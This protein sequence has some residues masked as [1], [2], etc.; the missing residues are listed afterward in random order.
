MSRSVTRFRSCAPGLAIAIAIGT[1]LLTSPPAHAQLLAREAA[2]TGLRFPTASATPETPATAAPIESD[3]AEA[4]F[5]GP[6]PP[7]A[8]DDDAS[9]APTPSA[10]A[11]TIGLTGDASIEAGV[12]DDDA[13]FDLTDALALDVMTNPAYPDS[14]KAI[15][16]EQI[17]DDFR[18]YDEVGRR[19]AKR[20]RAPGGLRRTSAGKMQ[21]GVARD[22]DLGFLAPQDLALRAISLLDPYTRDLGEQLCG[23]VGTPCPLPLEWNVSVP[24]VEL[25]WHFTDEAARIAYRDAALGVADTG[26]RV[27]KNG[28]LQNRGERESS[29][30]G[31]SG[32]YYAYYEGEDCGPSLAAPCLRV[33]FARGAWFDT[34]PPWADWSI[35]V[36]AWSVEPLDQLTIEFDRFGN[37]IVITEGWQQQQ[38]A[39]ATVTAPATVKDFF[40]ATIGASVMSARCTTCHALDTRQKIADQHGGLVTPSDV[41]LD[42]SIVTAGALINTC[43]SCHVVG[44]THLHTFDEERWATPTPAQDIDWGSIIASAGA[45]WA[46]EVCQRIVGHLTTPQAR[47]HHFH[48]DARLHWA[49]ADGRTPFGEQKTRA[50]PQDYYLFLKHFDAWNDA[51]ARCPL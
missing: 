44:A 14:T 1:A 25:T 48:E 16:L 24:L 2:G 13:L 35:S 38:A 26:L 4:S 10:Y 45:D 39:T 32:D 33:V 43:E 19:V 18:R 37:P 11:P 36:E 9:G 5:L 40:T 42:D 27:L 7:D 34:A 47:A 6:T 12:L 23:A 50:Q 41:F 8:S 17:A 28:V 46:R 29:G 22:H 3:H 21:I 31:V 20:V 30:W 51:G 15:L 49:V